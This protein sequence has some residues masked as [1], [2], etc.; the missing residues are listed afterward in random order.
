MVIEQAFWWCGF[1][2]LLV[3]ALF[4]FLAAWAY[5]REAF[6][7]CQ[8]LLA[9]LGIFWCCSTLWVEALIYIWYPDFDHLAPPSMKAD[10]RPGRYF[11]YCDV[12]ARIKCSTMLMSPFNR[13]LTYSGLVSPDIFVDFANASF[14][15]PFYL[16]HLLCVVLEGCSSP[17]PRPHFHH[18]YDEDQG[19][20]CCSF[21]TFMSITTLLVA[22]GT[23]GHACVQFYVLRTISF[24]HCLSYMVN[25]ALIP[26]VLKPIKEEE[27]EQDK[28][29][30]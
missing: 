21:R 13:L 18:R 26:S 20:E 11:P 29:W 14:G 22:I 10:Q 9:L 19:C 7:T 1:P 15:I 6:G 25:F 16:G 8:I 17:D 27:E 3:S 5:R 30:N 12:T 2:V 28:K 24:V 4:L 23:F